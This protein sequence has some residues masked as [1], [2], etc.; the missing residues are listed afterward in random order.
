MESQ[1]QARVSCYC[2]QPWKT[3][4]FSDGASQLVF[5]FT[6]S[7]L[8]ATER[9]NQSLLPHSFC[10]TGPFLSCRSPNF[11][12]LQGFQ[13]KP[14]SQGPPPH[15]IPWSQEDAPPLRSLQG[16][17]GITLLSVTPLL[18]ATESVITDGSQ[19]TCRRCL[20][21]LQGLTAAD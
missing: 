18:R 3:G 8:A 13:A 10:Q 9:M 7:T 1:G 20:H 19:S 15:R 5:H 14:S 12:Y 2:M 21:E 16:V 6:N 17:E 4:W 11:T